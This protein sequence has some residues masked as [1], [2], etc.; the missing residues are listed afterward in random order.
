MHLPILRGAISQPAL[1]P[2]LGLVKRNQNIMGPNSGIRSN[3]DKPNFLLSDIFLLLAQS[4][5]IMKRPADS[6]H[7]RNVI[8]TAVIA[9][10]WHSP[11]VRFGC[12]QS[13]SVFFALN[14]GSSQIQSKETRS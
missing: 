8:W 4:C 5:A 2:V 9:L 13:Q 10:E 7:T 6:T 1:G 12:C 3:R 11:W 14:P